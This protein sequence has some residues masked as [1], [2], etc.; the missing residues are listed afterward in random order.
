[1]TSK[2][3]QFDNYYEKNNQIIQ[4]MMYNIGID[5]NDNDIK[6]E[7]NNDIKY[8][9]NTENVKMCVPV[10]EKETSANFM[11]PINT[12]VGKNKSNCYREIAQFDIELEHQCNYGYFCPHKS[13]PKMCPFNHHE[14]EKTVI[15]KGE[16]IPDLLCRYE[17]P[18]KTNNGGVMCCM[19]PKCWYNHAK[20]RS[21][22]MKKNHYH[23]Y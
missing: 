17:R 22:R 21:D 18:W 10:R 12:L 11:I 4:I 7:Y 15:K 6:Y 19:N 16:L 2:V 3:I 8:E 20:G 23:K 5:I 14:M 1:M 9:Y 13:N